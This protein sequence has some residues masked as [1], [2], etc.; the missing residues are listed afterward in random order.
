MED[1]YRKK[2]RALS[3]VWIASY[4]LLGVISNIYTIYQRAV[5][6][7]NPITMLSGYQL[8]SLL[9]ML[10]YFMPMLLLVCRYSKL[11][12]MNK[13]HRVAQIVFVFI[14]I[15]TTFLFLLTVISLS[16]PGLF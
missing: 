11:A 15:W 7:Y 16:F 14:A 12:H 13:L 1:K 8:F 5:N 2:A 3:I 4:V 9:V 6:D 10:I